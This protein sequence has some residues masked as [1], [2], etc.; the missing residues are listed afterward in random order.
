MTR[1]A[2]AA[3]PS[4]DL[5]RTDGLTEADALPGPRPRHAARCAPDPRLS[6]CGDCGRSGRELLESLELGSV[7]ADT[8]TARPR[9]SSW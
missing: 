5:G 6:R 2:A 9:R 4:L 7:V 3:A 8:L 1:A